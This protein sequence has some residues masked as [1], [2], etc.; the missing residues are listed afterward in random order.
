MQHCLRTP[1]LVAILG[2]ETSHGAVHYRLLVV[3]GFVPEILDVKLLDETISVSSKDAIATARKLT[4]E[5]GLFSGI[6]SGASAFAAFQVRHGPNDR[7]L[8]AF[9]G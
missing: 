1:V 6:S 7:L 5:E 9:F 2:F 3:A 8:L 4:R